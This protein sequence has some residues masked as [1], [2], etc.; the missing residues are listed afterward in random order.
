MNSAIKEQFLT[1]AWQP[2]VGLSIPV[3]RCGSVDFTHLI[4]LSAVFMDII[5]KLSNRNRL[6]IGY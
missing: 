5:E 3:A 6:I 2:S 4:A 1:P